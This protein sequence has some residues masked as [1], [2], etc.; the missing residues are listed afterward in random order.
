ME[1]ISKALVSLGVFAAVVCGVILTIV[2]ICIGLSKISEYKNEKFERER[3][4]AD[5]NEKQ[6]DIELAELRK[7]TNQFGIDFLN[8][9]M[10]KIEGMSEQEKKE[11]QAQEKLAHKII[12]KA[13]EESLKEELER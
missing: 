12:I 7:Q 3:Q 10:K 13:I 4:K 2:I 8:E 11:W 6:L 1:G 5:A 9:H